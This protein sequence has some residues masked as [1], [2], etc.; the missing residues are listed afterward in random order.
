MPERRRLG[1]G[2]ELLSVLAET[3]A[4]LGLAYLTCEHWAANVA[5][6][7]LGST[8]ALPLG[9]RIEAGLM[10]TVIVLPQDRD[11]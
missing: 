6:R 7:H 8:L 2:S 5:A 11:K 9:R 10:R 1:V 3:A 4:E